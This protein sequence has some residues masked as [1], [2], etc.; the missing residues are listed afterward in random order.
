[1]RELLPPDT[2]QAEAVDARILETT[3]RLDGDAP[4][5]A[6]PSAPGAGGL[7]AVLLTAVLFAATKGKV[8]LVGL[9]KLPTLLS[10]FVT[11]GI[12][13]SMF[14]WK[15][16]LG[17]VA[18]IYVH[19][20]GH[21]VALRRYGIPASSPMFV[22]FL[23]AFVR[24]RQYPATEREDA[25]VG[26]AGPIWGLGAA[27]AAA[28]LWIALDSP[29]MAAIARI[30][31][32]INLF[33]LAPVWQLDGSRGWRALDRRQRWAS[34]AALLVG[35]VVSEDTFVLVL[36]LIAGFRATTGEAPARGDRGI[37]ATYVG[38]VLA[39]AAMLRFLPDPMR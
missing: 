3:R 14:G 34:A 26:L 17:F 36:T 24:M 10:M 39:L 33:N 35:W 30:G 5:A 16:A 2:R 38:L 25:T 15:F 11:V 18:S 23:G 37:L 27:L 8:L 28:A 7:G 22:P 21:V 31:A 29:L 1:M 12:Y 32:W 13:A 4:A 6:E 19:E 9:T 20:M